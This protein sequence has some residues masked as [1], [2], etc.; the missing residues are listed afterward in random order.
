MNMR[1]PGWAGTEQRR[2]TQ[3]SYKKYMKK[4]LKAILA[5]SMLSPLLPAPVSAAGR[6]V[7]GSDDRRELFDASPAERLLADSVVSLWRSE[8]VM[9]NRPARKFTL[10]TTS[11]SEDLDLCSGERFEE[12]PRGDDLCSGSLVGGDLVMTAGH[13]VNDQAK[14]DNLK[15]VFG[16]AIKNSGAGAPPTIGAEDVYSC[17]NI[18]ARAKVM[19]GPDY[20]L[21]RLDRTV[22]GHKP[23]EINRAG[24]LKKGAK[25]LLIGHPVGLPLKLAGGA[26]VRDVLPQG[27]FVADLDSFGGNSGSPVFNEATGLIEG[28]LIRGGED[29]EMAPEGCMTMAVNPQNGGRGE[30]V[31]SVSA[32]LS[33][34]PALTKGQSSA[35]V[36]VRDVKVTETPVKQADLSRYFNAA[37]R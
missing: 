4:T 13:C 2:R 26:A 21:I 8:N 20:A 3:Q 36:N 14:C 17:K 5:L 32:L 24:S 31:S 35:A 7:Y 22:A 25:V 33:F 11:F 30:D 23:L 9:E 12:Q 28:I 10:D 6:S 18:V 27:Y 1:F 19:D 34:I 29:F 16:F 37:F 15:V